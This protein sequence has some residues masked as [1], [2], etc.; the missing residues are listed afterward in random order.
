MI[1][2]RLACLPVILL[3]ALPAL[4]PAPASAAVSCDPTDPMCQQVID[5]Q[6][7]A[8]QIQQQLDDIKKNLANVQ[9]A[10]AKLDAVLAV[11]QKQRADQEAQIAATQKQID[12]LSRQIRLKE[13]EIDRASAH[14][15]IRE[16]VLDQRVRAMD[17]HGK[18][19]YMQL[20]LTSK[21]FNQLLDRVVVMQD[22][23]R[24]D[25]QLLSSL[26]SD[27][28][29]LQVLRDGLNQKKAEQETL[30]TKQQQQKAD[31]DVTIG[32]QNQALAYQQQLAAQLAAKQAELED[33]KKVA[34]AQVAYLQQQYDLAA[35]QLGGG[36]G[37]FMWP[38]RGPITQPFGCSQLLGEMVDYSCPYPHRKHTGLDIG[39]NYL[40][41]IHA[42]D[43]GIATVYPGSYGYG[44]YVIIVH[45]SGYSTLYGHMDHFA[46]H[47]G[48][49]LRGAVIGYEGSTG[50]STGPH[51]HFEI[52][53]NGVPYNPCT[54]LGC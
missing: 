45:G 23:V 30:L 40:T 42:A 28:Q 6:N 53:Y 31:L 33:A 4:A 24:G 2:R 14:I 50:Y 1:G 44:N 32:Q 47:N 46:I 36:S 51:L 10:I 38:E 43:S 11:L 13:A 16:Q 52:R 27:K 5:A 17:K 41:P 48:P 37:Q 12:D 9:A 21:D 7:Q 3:L 54:W 39:A 26:K 8:N 35:Q 49:V 15:Q 34:D 25:E 20:V 29:L 18:L 19:D 22:I